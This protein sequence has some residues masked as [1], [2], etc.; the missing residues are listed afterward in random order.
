MKP[1]RTILIVDD[2][3]EMAETLTDILEDYGYTVVI[4][5]DGYQALKCIKESPID[6]ALIDIIMPGING[7]ETFKEK[8]SGSRI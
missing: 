4:A 8:S 5:L 3:Q 1:K 6:I 7:V 2:K